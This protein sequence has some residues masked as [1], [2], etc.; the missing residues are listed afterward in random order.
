MAQ[1]PAS[2]DCLEPYLRAYSSLG[3]KEENYSQTQSV[4]LFYF[5]RLSIHIVI[6]MMRNDTKMTQNDEDRP[7]RTGMQQF[8]NSSAVWEKHQIKSFKVRVRYPH[9]LINLINTQSE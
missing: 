8:P 6:K 5:H 2:V 1:I 3:G 4:K 9:A 7:V